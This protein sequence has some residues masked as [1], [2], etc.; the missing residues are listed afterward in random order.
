MEIF[1]CCIKIK[2]QRNNHS[3]QKVITRLVI[4]HLG[5]FSGS[6]VIAV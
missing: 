1:S 2:M 4:V 3:Y 5:F 6:N